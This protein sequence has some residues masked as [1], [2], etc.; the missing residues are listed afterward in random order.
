MRENLLIVDSQGTSQ[1]LAGLLEREGY[2]CHSARGPIRTRAIL[3]EQPID[4]IVW[5]D[6]DDNR[7]LNQDLISEWMQFPAIP[8][9]HLFSGASTVTAA[10]LRQIRSSL[11]FDSSEQRLAQVVGTILNRTAAPEAAPIVGRSELAFRN[12]LVHLRAQRAGPS[13]PQQP[14]PQ[15]DGA[16]LGTTALNAAERE[17]LMAAPGGVRARRG[18][19]VRSWWAQLRQVTAAL[20]GRLAR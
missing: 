5:K 15:G 1:P 10:A 18:S 9:I 17:R 13:A 8:V 3:R 12:V 6:N 7:A 2:V 20:G 11:P 19:R 16:A 4:L 14:A